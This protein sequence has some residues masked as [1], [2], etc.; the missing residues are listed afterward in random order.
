[1]TT[2]A[3]PA[4]LVIGEALMDITDSADGVSETPGG[5]P[6]NIAMGLARRGVAAALLTHLGTDERG[7][8]IARHLEASGVGILPE[9]FHDVPTSTARATLDATGAATYEFDIAW[10]VPRGLSLGDTPVIHTG[11]LATFL[12]PGADAVQALLDAHPDAIVTFDPNIRPG[13]VG[14]P[15]DAR[16]RFERIARRA[17]VVKLSDEDAAFLYPDLDIAAVIAA[18]LTLGPAIVAVTRGGSGA[19]LATHEGVVEVT[20]PRVEVVDTIGAGDTF[21]ASL[22]VEPLLRAG[23]TPRA[24][25]LTEIG[26]RAAE[27]AAITVSRVG[28][29]L[30]WAHELDD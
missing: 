4:V 7:R 21:M 19:T 29:D 18:I 3:R 10:E 1:M 26:T 16:S 11:S 9:S 8:A 27:A 28:A 6:A 13:L 24:A 2:P 23:S 12:N 30:P 25:Q 17:R 20:A 22:L 15:E 14:S 5:G